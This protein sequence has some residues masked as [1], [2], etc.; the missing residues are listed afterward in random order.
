[1]RNFRLTSHLAPALLLGLL[2]FGCSRKEEARQPEAAPSVAPE[3]KVLATVN[4]D[5]ITMGEFLERF[6]RAGLKPEKDAELQ[7]KEDFLNR[8]IERKMMLREAQRRR[9]K[10]SLPEINKRI[11][12]M[13]TEQGKDVKETLGGLGIDYEK[14]KSDVWEDM[15]IERLISH[16]VLRGVHVSAAE[17]RRYYQENPQ[18]FQRP[19]QVRVRQIVVATEEEAQKVLDQ[20]QNEKADFAA[21]ARKKSTAPEAEEGGDLGYFAM[22]DMPGEF[23]VVFGLPRGG[24]SGVVKSPYGFH[25]FKLEEKRK[26]GR[27]GLEDASKEIAEKLSRQKQDLRYKQW[28]TEL[29]GRTQFVV[30]Y[31]GLQQ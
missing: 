24:I 22:G 31:Q 30:N 28:L 20:L 8:L 27:V 11:E 5:P 15:M 25:I 18:E 10:I 7:V 3:V 9:I 26:A 17:I 14:W 23:N 16:E 12:T 1:M 13:K 19:E 29:R 6:A 4:G 21:L 2:F